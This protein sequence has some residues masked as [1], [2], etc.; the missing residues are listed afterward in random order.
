MELFHLLSENDAEE[1]E[2][3]EFGYPEGWSTLGDGSATLEFR[4]EIFG[5]EDNRWCC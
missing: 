3:D 2:P 5:K 1:G 4:S